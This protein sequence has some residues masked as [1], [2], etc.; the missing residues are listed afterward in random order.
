MRRVKDLLGERL[1][2]EYGLIVSFG[3]RET[4]GGD[5]LT[6][7][8]SEM[9]FEMPDGVKVEDSEFTEEE[10]I[11]ADPTG[12]EVSR[13]GF[14]RAEVVRMGQVDIVEDR[15]DLG[16]LDAGPFWT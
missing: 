7:V 1:I 14:T 3:R 13:M 5:R 2:G 4:E 6:E 9:M 12:F 16:A 8:T 11:D 15:E 10:M